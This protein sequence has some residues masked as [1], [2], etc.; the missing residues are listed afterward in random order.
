MTHS[1]MTHSGMTNSGMT[2][3]GLAH[4]SVT[5]P[6]VIHTGRCKPACPQRD[7]PGRDPRW[8]ASDVTIPG[9]SR[10]L[11]WQW[12]RRGGA[13]RFGVLLA[14]GLRA[15]PGT[16]VALS[17]SGRAEL[18][19]GPSPPRCDLLVDTYGGMLGFLVRLLWS[20][21][22]A[23][24]LARRVRELR[25]DL[26]ICAQPGPLDLLMAAALRRLRVP[27]IVV[28][29]DAE[30]HPGDG[31]PFQMML[32][33]M[34]CRRSSAIVA[35]TAHVADRLRELGLAGSPTRPLLLS[36]LPP[37][38]FD[39]PPPLPPTRG[40]PVHL[41]SFGRLLPYKGLDLLAETLRHLGPRTDAEIRVVGDG[42][43]TPALAALRALPGV[44]VENRWV[45]EAEVSALLGWADALILTY[46][47]ASQSGVAAAALAAGRRL[48]ATRVG[49]L[50][51]QLQDEPLAILC[52]P[53]ARSL[54]AALRD[55]IASPGSPDPPVDAGA[56]WR[57]MAV[58]LLSWAKVA[59]G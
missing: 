37:L 22:A 39:Q 26:A 4:T 55:L 15:I 16:D 31:M 25:P 33:G 9:T 57:D 23:R 3:S 44:T 7:L 11:V 43:E 14:A 56:A 27:F 6:D 35:L 46:T 47:E 1:G 24:G 29:H 32:Q 13:P 19:G 8:R 52:P 21:L 5:H 54:A 45:P 28:V 42:P 10:V 2:N 17:M 12:G 49:G 34:L 50:T 58:E 36:R 48:V 38:T 18:L 51:E 41:L 20:P 30:T 53:D 59:V 40:G